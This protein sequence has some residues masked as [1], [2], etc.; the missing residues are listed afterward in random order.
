MLK[1]FWL[2]IIYK[3]QIKYMVFVCLKIE[4]NHTIYFIYL[5]NYR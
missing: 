5:L 2:K 4:V 1:C 3:K